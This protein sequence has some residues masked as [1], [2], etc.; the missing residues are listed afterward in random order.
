MIR[1]STRGRYAL[2][3]MV[4][5]AQ[6]PADGPVPRED[7]AVKSSRSSPQARRSAGL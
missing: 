4:D 5:V 3:A 2:R 7:V 6:Y 1:D